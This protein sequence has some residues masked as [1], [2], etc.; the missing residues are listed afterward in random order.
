MKRKQ[1]IPDV[2]Q[3]RSEQDALDQSIALNRIVMSLLKSQKESNK[4]LF[5][6]LIISLLMNVVIVAGFL[7]YESTWEHTVTTTETITTTQEVEGDS[8]QINNVQGNQYKDNSVHNEGGL[9]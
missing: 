5:I 3:I 1:T 2:N 4:R 9:D 8:A 7:Y 6:A